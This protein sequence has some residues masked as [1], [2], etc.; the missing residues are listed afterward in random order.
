MYRSNF[1]SI[2]VSASGGVSGRSLLSATVSPG[3]YILVARSSG[4]TTGAFT[5]KTSF[6][7]VAPLVCPVREIGLEETVEGTLASGDCALSDVLPDSASD[8]FVHR[9]QVAV[10]AAGTLRIELSSADFVPVVSLRDA[11]GQ[12]VGEEAGASLSVGVTHGSYVVFVT[13]V[14]PASGRCTVKTAFQPAEGDPATGTAR[15]R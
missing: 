13:S 9:Y 8:A 5:L 7:T 2:A 14:R 3:E 4:L 1:S 10:T 15:R 12:P 11:G 6:Q